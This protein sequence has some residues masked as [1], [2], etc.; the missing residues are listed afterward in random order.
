MFSIVLLLISSVLWMA[1]A[2][3]KG[4]LKKGE[5]I[6]SDIAGIRLYV[7]MWSMAAIGLSVYT[8]NTYIENEYLINN[9]QKYEAVLTDYRVNQRGTGKYGTTSYSPSFEFI[10]V[11]GDS[12]EYNLTSTFLVKPIRGSS[13]TVFYNPKNKETYVMNA[14]MIIG[15]GLVL[16]A[17]ALS[18]YF[19]LGMMVFSIIP[20][21]MRSK[22]IGLQMVKGS[23]IMAGFIIIQVLISYLLFWGYK[24][25]AIL[26]IVYL[27]AST[28]AVWRYSKRYRVEWL[29]VFNSSELAI[30]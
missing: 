24:Y 15:G 4:L 2:V 12:I 1:Y 5:V 26:I 23:M 10:T 19:Y 30:F 21:K 11:A 18:L 22:W 14:Q 8:V 16:L 6:T 9:L 25:Y 7:C 13:Y 28:Y 3:P 17:I 29:R 27:L 20:F